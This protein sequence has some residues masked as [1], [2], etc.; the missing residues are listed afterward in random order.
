MSQPNNFYTELLKRNKQTLAQRVVELTRI[1]DLETE[2]VRNLEKKVVMLLGRAP[3]P[4]HVLDVLEYIKPGVWI[5]TKAPEL[6]A[7]VDKHT[8]ELDWLAA[9]DSDQARDNTC[10]RILYNYITEGT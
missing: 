1:C 3:T 2:K 8:I 10:F 6:R 7:A 4:K 9:S 5:T